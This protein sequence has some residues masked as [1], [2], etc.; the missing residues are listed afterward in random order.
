MSPELL[1]FED[2]VEV[3]GI[4]PRRAVAHFQSVEYLRTAIGAMLA[5]GLVSMKR[6]TDCPRVEVA[7]W[8][9]NSWVRD[10]AAWAECV[11]DESLYI[12]ATP[13]GERYFLT[14]RE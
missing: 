12:E 7:A 4:P 6:G 8:E 2:L 10:A 14:G 13:A 1:L 3:G 5:A 11:E 9:W